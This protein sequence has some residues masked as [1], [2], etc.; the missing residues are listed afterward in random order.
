MPAV[1]GKNLLRQQN[2]RNNGRIRMLQLQMNKG[3]ITGIY[4]GRYSEPVDITDGTGRFGCLAYTLCDQDINGEEKPE[5]V[6]FREQYAGYDERFRN[7]RIGTELE[8]CAW[9]NGVSLTLSCEG[10]A[11]DGT[12]IFLPFN[13]ISRKNGCWKQQF[14]VSSP[15]RAEDGHTFFFLKRPDG[16]HLAC[17]ADSPIDGYQINYSPYLAG[18]FIRGITFWVQKDRAYATPRKE[19]RSIRVYIAPADSYEAAMEMAGRLWNMPGLTYGCSSVQAGNRFVFRPVGQWDFIQVTAPSGKIQHLT[20]P[21]FTPEEYGFYRAAAFR[22]GKPGMDCTLFCYDDLKA[23]YGR[24]CRSIVQDKTQ[25]IGRAAD[26]TAVWKPPF[27]SYRGYEDFNLC[28]HAMWAWAHLEYLNRYENDPRL[29]ADVQNLLRIMAPENGINLPRSTYD[30]TTGYNTFTDHRIQEAYNGVNILLAAYRRYQDERL[31]ELAITVLTNRIR[32][33]RHEDGGLYRH[34]SDGAT[35]EV[36]NYTTVTAMVFPIADM[37]CL[38]ESKNDPR[39]AWF[40]EVAVGIADHLVRRGLDFP[41]EGGANEDA[42]PEVE[43]GSMSCSALSVL[44]VAAKLEKKQEY[45]DYAGQVLA[46]HDA[47]TV[48]TPHP[49]MF[50]SSLRWWETVWEGDSDGPAVCYGHAWSIWRGEA[51]YWYAMLC[52]DDG[53]LLDSWNC[54]MSNFSKTDAAGN[55]YAIYQHDSMSCG[56]VNTHGKDM[57]RSDR[58]GFPRRKDR[59]LSRYPWA[60]GANTWFETVAILKDTVLG[61]STENGVIKPYFENIKTLY[62]GDFLGSLQIDLPD[63]VNIVSQKP[64]TFQKQILTVG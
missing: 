63:T 58:T 9:E 2:V 10:A 23:M 47:Y 43:E 55:M 14:T 1:L 28:E 31:L 11:V 40:R 32:A 50:R 25:V 24:A 7:T 62:I 52:H 51:E 3:Y 13:F 42:G 30:P 26:G 4:D 37:A 17:I 35:A 60:R 39:A 48:H 41:T 21:E 12:G 29:D 46:L 33:D 18:H 45:L 34:G 38:L 53:R 61:G 57:D 22:N 36:A 59:T 16:N 8:A 6:P 27:C 64:V 20:Q 19:H 54:F 44:Y 5:F 56:A 15:Y 49:C